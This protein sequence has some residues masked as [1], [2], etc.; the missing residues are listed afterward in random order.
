M[1]NRIFDFAADD[2]DRLIDEGDPEALF[3]AAKALQ[4]W[5]A[6][7]LEI[8]ELAL[9]DWA[10]IALA[11]PR[12]R[13]G[14]PELHSLIQRL[15]AIHPADEEPAE[16]GVATRYQRWDGLAQ[17]LETR[18]HG[19]DHH[20]P[21]E[22]ERRTHMPELRQALAAGGAQG[23]RFAELLKTM[24]LAKS[25]L[26][27]LLALA[28]AAG[29]AERDR[30]GGEVWAVPMGS[31][32]TAEGASAVAAPRPCIEPMRLSPKRGAHLL[33]A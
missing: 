8:T 10:N 12:R 20:Q 11:K 23:V 19:L 16:L 1:K 33:A 15:Q 17:L 31:W 9:Y 27:Q 29:L 4:Q 26:S 3:R 21:G 28:E 14:L 2:P 7:A 5:T 30:R 25:R 18:V 13:Q 32:A 6:R 22:A 24:G